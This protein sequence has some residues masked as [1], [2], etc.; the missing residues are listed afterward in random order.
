M[1]NQSSEKSKVTSKQEHQ[2]HMISAEAWNTQM[3]VY[4]FIYLYNNLTE[5]NAVQVGMT[6]Q[7]QVL[8][9][10]TSRDTKLNDM[11]LRPIRS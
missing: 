8:L 3:G 7:N 5:H 6:W 2:L 1:K 11:V 4:E 9:E 10:K